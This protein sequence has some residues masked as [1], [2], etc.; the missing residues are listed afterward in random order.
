MKRPLHMVLRKRKRPH[1][2]VRKR[3]RLLYILW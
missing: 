3:K 2:V 1:E